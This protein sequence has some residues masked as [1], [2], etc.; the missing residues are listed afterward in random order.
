M[1][2]H[3]RAS[4]PLLVAIEPDVSDPRWGEDFRISL[5]MFEDARVKVR[6]ANEAAVERG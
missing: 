5:S 2:G 6:Y 4:H 3:L 1:L